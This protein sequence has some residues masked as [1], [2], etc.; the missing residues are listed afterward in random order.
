M[1]EESK[2]QGK[3]IAKLKADGWLVNK[4]ITMSHSGWPD[5]IALKSGITMFVE[6]KSKGKKPSDLQAYCIK[7]LN[8]SGVIA[9]YADS[10]EMFSQNMFLNIRFTAPQSKKS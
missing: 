5:I 6:V 1:A 2:L 4:L 8:D 9:F 3:I 7:Q 10:M